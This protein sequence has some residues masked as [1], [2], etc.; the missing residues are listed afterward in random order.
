MKGFIGTMTILF[1]LG[2]SACQSS[3]PMLEGKTHDYSLK[4]KCPTLLVMK[5]GETLKFSAAENPSTG[6]QWQLVQPL[7]LFKT[8][9]SFVSHQSEEG[10]LGVGG[11]KTFKFKAEQ[12]GQDLIELVHIRPWESSKQPE[13]QWSCRIRVS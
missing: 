3:N 6:Y 10:A 5:V 7:K 1:G 2:L 13:Q 8:E 4:Q 12:P 9:E 11:T